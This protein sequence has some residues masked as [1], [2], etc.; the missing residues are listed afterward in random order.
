MIRRTDIE[1][2]LATRRFGRPLYWYDRID[3]TNRELLEWAVRGAEEG[4]L[5]VADEQTAGRGRR[6][7]QW[8]APPGTGLLMSLL[9]RPRQ[10]VGLLPLMTGAVLAETI[11]AVSGAR[12]T[13]KWPNDVL[14]GERKVAGVLVETVIQRGQQAAVIGMGINVNMQA[15]DFERVGMP[16][17]SLRLET[18]QIWEREDLLAALLP[19]LETAYDALQAGAWSLDAWRARAPML[20]KPITVFE[21]EDAW[22]GVALDV[23]EDGALLVQ[24]EEGVR[25]I[26]AADVRVRFP[27]SET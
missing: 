1:A 24:T 19:R 8:I 9:V 2:R 18:G 23:A 11:E 7:R 3:S 20:G 5:L 12:A 25:A 13:V 21:E 6:G 4:T 17:T 16:A 27:S 10:A 26:Y 22:Y 14:I 15:H